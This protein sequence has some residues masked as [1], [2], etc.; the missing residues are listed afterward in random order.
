MPESTWLIETEGLTKRYGEVLAVDNLSLRVAEGGVFGLLGPNGSGKTTTMGMLLGLV[1]PSAGS[2]R[3]FGEAPGTHTDALHRIGAIIEGPA[4]YPY[5]SGR[6]NLHY[7]Q[8]ISGR[9]SAKD[10]DGLLD[11]LE[12]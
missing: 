1:K 11:Q 12:L 7:F 9:G 8:G 3:L 6:A 2:F 10:V 5:L 4:F